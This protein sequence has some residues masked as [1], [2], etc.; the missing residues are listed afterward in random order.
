MN[1][2]IHTLGLFVL[3]LA[4]LWRRDAGSRAAAYAALLSGT[5]VFLLG[6]HVFDW[7]TPYL[8]ALL[9]AALSYALPALWARYRP[10]PV[11]AA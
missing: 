9:A 6:S 2:L 1:K 10:R 11:A 3:L 7:E 8:A 5:G 4:S